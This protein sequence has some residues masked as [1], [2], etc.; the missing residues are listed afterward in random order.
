[1]DNAHESKSTDN[2]RLAENG[3]ESESSGV[4]VEEEECTPPRDEKKY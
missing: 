4:L 2:E 1:M 3:Q